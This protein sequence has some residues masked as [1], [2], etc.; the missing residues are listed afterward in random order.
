MLRPANSGARND[1]NAM[2]YYPLLLDL[3]GKKCVVAGGGSVAQRKVNSLLKAKARVWVISP[4]LTKGLEQLKRKKS[5]VYVKS[6]YQEKYL[7]GAF[8]VIAATSDEKI[9]RRVAYDAQANGMLTNVVDAPR[10][11][12]FIVP[13]SITRGDLIISISTSGKAPG[14]SRGLRI[15]LCKS[16]VPRYAKL[17]RLLED[18][19]GRLK[20]KYPSQALRAKLFKRLVNIQIPES[21]TGNKSRMRAYLE[22]LLNDIEEKINNKVHRVHLSS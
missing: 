7:Q 10:L 3:K 14:L 16:I 22:M 11:S 5:I 1:G 9:N 4:D 6:H 17:L 21:L 20:S 15:E 12:N 8:L 2:K 19:R 18:I 13:S